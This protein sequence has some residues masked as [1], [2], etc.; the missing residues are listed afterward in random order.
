[1]ADGR[2]LSPSFQ[3]RF[4][5]QLLVLHQQKLRQLKENKILNKSFA[6]SVGKKI[7]RNVLI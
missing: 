6:V 7:L 1:M 3:T 5:Q 4:S 2:S